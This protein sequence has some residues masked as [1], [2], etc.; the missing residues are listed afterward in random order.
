MH[1][2]AKHLWGE[3]A[4]SAIAERLKPDTRRVMLQEPLVAMSWYPSWML[5]DWC[6]SVWNGPA[7]QRDAIYATFVDRTIDLG[8]SRVRRLFVG[9]LTPELLAT[10]AAKEWR[11]EHSHGT[12]DVVLGTQGATATFRDSPFVEVPIMQVGLAECFRHLASLSRVHVVRE[13]H[14]TE[15]GR[16][17]VELIWR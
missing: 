3:H 1:A 12:V 16:L 9:M 8:W 13:T 4:F 6:Q 5:I 10:R 17:V 14:H 7:R 2:A 15:P 11:N